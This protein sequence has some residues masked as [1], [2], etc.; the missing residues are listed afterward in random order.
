MYIIVLVVWL[1][2][3]SILTPK[4]IRTE[5]DYNVKYNNLQE[6]NEALKDKVGVVAKETDQNTKFVWKE[7]FCQQVP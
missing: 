7:G 4:L 6:C 1:H 5:V 3:F 2:H